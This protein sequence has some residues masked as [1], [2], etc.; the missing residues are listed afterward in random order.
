MKNTRKETGTFPLIMFIISLMIFAFLYGIAAA[1]FN[2]FPYAYFQKAWNASKTVWLD[3]TAL[4]SL[5]PARYPDKSGVMVYNREK[6]YNGITLITGTW[7]ENDKEWSHQIRLVDMQGNL[8]HHWKID[9]NEIWPESPHNDHTAGIHNHKHRTTIHG[10]KVYPNGDVVFN[11]EY[12]TLVKMDWDGNIIWKLPYR[13][14]H[15]VYEDDIGNLWVCGAKWRE[16]KVLEYPHLLPNFAEDTIVKIS[17]D[18]EIEREI[19]ILKAIYESNYPGLLFFVGNTSYWVHNTGDITHLNDVEVLNPEMAQHFKTFKAGDILVSMR[20]NN[21][22]MVIDGDTEK[23]KWALTH[24]F[25]AQHDPDFY[26]DG[27]ITVFDNGL[28]KTNSDSVLGGTR[29]LKVDP[30]TN[31]VT[32]IYGHRE[33]QYF[34]TNQGGKHQHLLNGNILITECAAGRVFEVNLEGEIVWDWYTSK[35]DEDH[36]GEIMQG[37]RLPEGYL[38]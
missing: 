30:V 20:H 17:A 26:P 38:K 1:S 27:T 34:Y 37:T 19:S 29:I 31:S 5:N 7:K 35:W 28:A 3:A 36:V 24:P 13:T 23:I 33:D 11:L 32:P 14:H 15:S 4:H 10:V 9:P 12:L 6:A 21:T 22:I 16:E 18:G 2:W 25:V 8:V